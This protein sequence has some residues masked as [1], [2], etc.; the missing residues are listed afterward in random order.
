[1]TTAPT[2]PPTGGAVL[3]QVLEWFVSGHALLAAAEL[4][5]AD[6]LTDEPQSTETLARATGTDPS[7][8]TRLLRVL[9]TAGLVSEVEPGRFA[10]TAAGQSLRSGPASLK[11]GLQLVSQF[12][13]QPLTQT[14]EAVRTGETGFAR[15]FGM[16]FYE[17][18]DQH[19]ELDAVFGRLMSVLR[20]FSGP[21]TDAYDFSG[22]HTLVD[23]GGGHGWRTIEVLQAHP[24]I[25]GVVFDR[26]GVVD[27]TRRALAD[28]G[29][30][31]RTEVVGGSF[32]E[33]VPDGGDC[34]MLSAVIPNWGDEA[35]QRILTTVRQAMA[36]ET[37]LV[38]FEP[39]RP[40]GD[41]PHIAKTIDLLMLILL[42]GQVRSEAELSRLLETA[43]LRLQ[44][45]HTTP[46][47]L[48]AVEAIPI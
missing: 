39:V 8:L 25:H 3:V 43:G 36:T 14:A 41:E 26:P 34:Y 28:A 15:L 46:S 9:A 48:A 16:P 33:K 20:D 29:L 19:P 6:A 18:L 13:L 22:V 2:S 27:H 45:V 38:L 11:P 7:S 35:A 4:D 40:E 31:D 32:F 17:Y 5:V 24:H 37:R 1:M 30:D 10:L 42:G 23:V 44:R 12:M 21:V 47:A